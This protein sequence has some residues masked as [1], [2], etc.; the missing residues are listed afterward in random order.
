VELLE[1]VNHRLYQIERVI[2]VVALMVMSVVVF[3][4]VVHRRY[5]DPES[6]LANKIAKWIDAERGSATWQSLQDIAGPL[7]L[8]FIAAV[9]YLG[10]RTASRRALW[11][12]SGEVGKSAEQLRGE[13]LSHLQCAIYTVVLIGVSW[14]ALVLMF[15]TGNIE[16]YECIELSLEGRFSLD[17]GL[18]PAG[19]DW[20]QPFGLILTLWVAFL[21]ASMATKDNVHL[22]VEA[23]QQAM[24]DKIKRISGLISG[25]LTAGFCMLLAYLGW[26]YVGFMYEQWEISDRLGGLHDGIDIPR[27]LS[28]VAVPL[29]Y[30]LMGLRFIGTGVL[31]FRGELEDTPPELR[32][33]EKIV[34]SNEASEPVTGEP[35]PPDPPNEAVA[36][37]EQEE[38]ER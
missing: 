5:A 3:L 21:G 1:K 30:V 33:L 31:A 28:F 27:F 14:L 6:V 7:S 10:F 29:A 8:V 15:G 11:D 2:V 4:S 9:I 32:E 19:L 17:C 16:Q 35:E 12:R 34:A 24:P 23:V 38:S 18:F 25:L 26:R 22:K 13:P 20:A 36:G 37:D